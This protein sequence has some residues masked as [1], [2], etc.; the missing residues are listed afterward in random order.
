[1][2]ATVLP[3]PTQR[4]SNGF[5]VRLTEDAEPRVELTV[6]LWTVARF[7]VGEARALRDA[8]DALLAS[9]GGPCG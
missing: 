5:E 6:G 1:M 8:L 3:F 2:S 7:S 9:A 4:S